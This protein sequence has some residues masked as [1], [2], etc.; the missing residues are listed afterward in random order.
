MPEAPLGCFGS[1]GDKHCAPPASQVNRSKVV[2]PVKIP[3]ASKICTSPA[4]QPPSLW[5]IPHQAGDLAGE[6][7][8][9][10]VF[11]QLFLVPHF[12]LAGLGEADPCGRGSTGLSQV[13]EVGQQGRCQC[14]GRGR[15][16]QH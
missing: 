10:G 5:S 13:K 15:A 2:T 8:G 16:H 6:Q 14:S 3:Q 12:L 7:E 9:S 11:E 4:P 1:G